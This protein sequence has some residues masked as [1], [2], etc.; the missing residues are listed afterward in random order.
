MLPQLPD[1]TI[2]RPQLT[3][4]FAA[5]TRVLLI[6]A[7]AGYGKTTTALQWAHAQSMRV[8]WVA[9][10]SGDAHTPAFIGHL[11]DTLDALGAALGT[12]VD[13]LFQNNA[14]PQPAQVGRLL[15]QGLITLDEPVTLVLD[16][17]HELQSQQNYAIVQEMV[18]NLPAGCAVILSTRY[19]PPLPLARWRASRW[20]TEIRVADLRFST[21]EAT[22]FLRTMSA[23]DLDPEPLNTFIR[24]TEGWAIGLV[25]ATLALPT[26]A[27]PEQFLAAFNGTHV[28]LA[29]Y[30][31]EEVLPRDNHA[32]HDF[33]VQTSALSQLSAPLC[34]VCLQRNDSAQ[35][36]QQLR[37]FNL[38]LFPLDEAG[39]WWRYHHFLGDVLRIQ[40]A[41]DEARRI[42][43]RAAAWHAQQY[44]VELASR[45]YTQLEDWPALARLIAQQ[46]VPALIAGH[47]L[48]LRRLL[49]YLPAD[50]TPQHYEI[51][52]ARTWFLVHSRQLQGAQ[53]ALQQA[54]ALLPDNADGRQQS[55]LHLMDALIATYSGQTAHAQAELNRIDPESDPKL[56]GMARWVASLVDWQLGNVQ[57]AIESNRNNLQEPIAQADTFAYSGMSY[58][59]SVYLHATGRRREAL[60]VCEHAAEQ[61]T[62]RWG[63]P[64]LVSR[65]LYLQAAR[66]HFDANNL[67]AT[68]QD[69]R[70]HARLQSALDLRE[71][72]LIGHLLAA[73]LEVARG[74]NERAFAEVEAAFRVAYAAETERLR[75][76]V[77]AQAALLHWFGGNATPLRQW[78]AT[79][80]APEMVMEEWQLVF[81]VGLIEKGHHAAATKFIATQR[82]YLESRHGVRLLLCL[83]ILAA[84]NDHRQQQP[85]RAYK[86]LAR[87]AAVAAP[88]AFIRPFI[89][90]GADVLYL[91]HDSAEAPADFLAQLPGGNG[92]TTH[93]DKSQLAYVE[94]LTERERAT[95]QLVA[96]GLSNKDIAARLHVAVSTVRTHLKNTYS[97]LQ[98]ESR[99]HAIALARSHG[100]L[101]E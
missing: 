22:A 39:Q 74:H 3:T 12:E 73:R 68:E 54:Y 45:Y 79:A 44:D 34:D 93:T 23:V 89:D 1:N 92:S 64:L 65:L 62:D 2:E 16:D 56:L 70:V 96:E 87:A 10:N 42:L 57:Q 52:L 21:E 94:P 55:W 33:L 35:M 15:V 61:M 28:Y 75:T 51:W 83:D 40:L 50:F 41:D 100:L 27:A 60:A 69:L 95:L 46:V 53:H 36:L 77:E 4:R 67:D 85:A 17:L 84:L 32:L 49:S 91:L 5:N 81:L 18:E 26:T 13:S 6:S 66:L 29:S 101:A 20:L 99:T 47:H 24:N 80:E 78:M 97:K 14:T 48:I 9:L 37:A 11:V 58:Y 59:L 31:L 98:A 30:F 8:G 90:Y 63:D 19:D 43:S 86:H 88:E 38:F 72:I 76:Q 71:A 82:I 7:P 25:M